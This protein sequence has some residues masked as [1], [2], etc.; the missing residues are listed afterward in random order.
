MFHIVTSYNAPIA[1]PAKRDSMSRCCYV[2]IESVMLLIIIYITI[3]NNSKG[4][5]TFSACINLLSRLITI[6]INADK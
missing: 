3:L 4:V 1:E 5:Q 6:F 2:C